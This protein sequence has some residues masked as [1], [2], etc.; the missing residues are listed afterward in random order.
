MGHSGGL[1]WVAD[2][3]LTMRHY[4]DA[5]SFAF[6]WNSSEGTISQIAVVG[7]C[8]RT[9][10]NR[11]PEHCDPCRANSDVQNRTV[12]RSLDCFHCHVWREKM[13][14]PFT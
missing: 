14:T 7:Y 6:A 2:V 9:E 1:R 10:V 12:E 11:R 13:A 5:I 3:A 8:P 4:A